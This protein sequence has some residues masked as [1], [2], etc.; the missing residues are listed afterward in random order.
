M[1]DAGL[2]AGFVVLTG[3]QC[4]FSNGPSAHP[5]YLNP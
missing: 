5:G 4:D 2:W 1:N 3:D